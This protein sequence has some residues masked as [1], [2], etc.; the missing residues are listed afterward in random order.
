MEGATQAPEMPRRSKP[1]P[2][3]VKVARR[4]R[5]IRLEHGLTLEKLAYESDFPK[6][7]LSNIE[8]GLVRPTVE[9][10]RALAP[11]LDALPADFVNFPTDGPRQRL[12]EF[13]RTMTKADVRRLLRH[14]RDNFSR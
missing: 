3:A 7:H 12:I 2:L 4:I 13:T 5:K 8:K 10:L 14:A 6:G 9:T 11:R 1:D